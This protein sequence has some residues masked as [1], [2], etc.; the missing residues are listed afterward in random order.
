MRT[1]YGIAACL[2]I[3]GIALSTGCG[4]LQNYSGAPLPKE[5][6]AS[7]RCPF[8]GGST[9]V[10]Y[11]DQADPDHFIPFHHTV[12]IRPG[13]HTVY[14]ETSYPYEPG[15]RSITF[16]AEAGHTYTLVVKTIEAGR[17]KADVVDITEQGK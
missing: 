11:I 17:F 15:E 5:T 10:Q 4:T 9:P 8:W 14:F 6:V 7:F 1:T 16:E 12:Q 3:A 2:C 13:L